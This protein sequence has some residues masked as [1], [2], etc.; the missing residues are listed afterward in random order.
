MPLGNTRLIPE[1]FQ[2]HHQVTVRGQMTAECTI[3][4]ATNAVWPPAFNEATRTSERPEPAVIYS[5]ICRARGPIT[6]AGNTTTADR[7][8]ALNAYTVTIPATAAAVQVG[9]VVKVTA[10]PDDTA[11][12]GLTLIVTAAQRGS[13]TWQRDLA[14]DLSQPVTR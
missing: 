12:V 9:D 8:Q 10:C 14:C 13:I 7:I 2:E 4:R 5:G 1:R 6:S 3:T 11:L